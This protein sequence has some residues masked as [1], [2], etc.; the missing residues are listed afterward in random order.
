MFGN[1]R[2][3]LGIE[4]ENAVVKVTFELGGEKR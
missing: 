3:V 4:L 2:E 1:V